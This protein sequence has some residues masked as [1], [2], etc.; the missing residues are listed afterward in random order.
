MIERISAL[1]MHSVAA[2][3]GTAL[4]GGME[5]ALGCQ[6]RLMHE[7]AKFGLPEVHLGILPGAGG[8]QR[9]PRIVGCETAI[10]M[11]TKIVTRTELLAKHGTT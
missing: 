10:Q 8:T 6:Y 7:G 1:G 11:M 9:L 3:H 4:G 2:V 5:L